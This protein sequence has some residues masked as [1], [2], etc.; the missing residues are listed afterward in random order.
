[1]REKNRNIIATV[2]KNVMNINW[3]EWTVKDMV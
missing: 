2:E 1:M 3:D